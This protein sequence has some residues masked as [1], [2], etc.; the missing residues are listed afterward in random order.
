MESD[1]MTLLV[2][3]D[4]SAFSEHALAL[5]VEIAVRMQRSEGAV[6]NLLWRGLSRLALRI[7]D[8]RREPE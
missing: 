4:F 2:G 5:A 1:K 3:I 8:L 7:G 6:N